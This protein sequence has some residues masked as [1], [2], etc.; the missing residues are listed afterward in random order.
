MPGW[1]HSCAHLCRSPR[2][3]KGLQLCLRFE[4]MNF[5]DFFPG[6]SH[7]E[8]DAGCHERCGCPLLGSRI[9]PR[10]QLN[11]GPAGKRQEAWQWL[12]R[13]S[14]CRASQRVRT[15]ASYSDAMPYMH[16]FGIFWTRT[17]TRFCNCAHFLRFPHPTAGTTLTS[18]SRVLLIS[19]RV[20]L[21]SSPTIFFLAVPIDLLL[22]WSRCPSATLFHVCIEVGLVG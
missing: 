13:P 7:V 9:A 6:L 1:Y 4:S 11:H 15:Q 18:S 22:L 21:V 5:F 20:F 3:L 19:P 17:I 10:K 14:C 8:V 16:C 12:L 2:T